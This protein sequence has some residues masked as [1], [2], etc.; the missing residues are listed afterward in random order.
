MARPHR[1]VVEHL[2]PRNNT[3]TLYLDVADHLCLQQITVPAMTHPNPVHTGTL[4]ILN[5]SRESSSPPPVH[6]HTALKIER[7]TMHVI[8]V[9][10][11]GKSSTSGTLTVHHTIILERER[12]H[13]APIVT[14]ERLF[15]FRGKTQSLPHERGD[16][17]CPHH[18]PS[19][20]VHSHI[21]RGKHI[22]PPACSATYSTCADCRA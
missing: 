13:P 7:P 22:L 1:I 21:T 15:P 8:I 9:L 18:H 12:P 11:W 16:F 19:N 4:A 2:V 14:H 10:P 3:N 20:S 17:W 5:L 6:T